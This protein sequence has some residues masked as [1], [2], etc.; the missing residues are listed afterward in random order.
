MKDF[1]IFVRFIRKSSTGM[2]TLAEILTA[3]IAKG[4]KSKAFVAAQLGVSERTVENY[5]KGARS[6]KPEV[7]VKLS[8]ML[9]FELSELSNNE[10]QNVPS[11]NGSTNHIS[12]PTTPYVKNPASNETGLKDELIV[13]YKEQIRLLKQELANSNHL[14]QLITALQLPES[15]HDLTD[16]VKAIAGIVEE[17]R[18]FL[19]RLASLVSDPD[20]SL[21]DQG[22]I[23]TYGST[24]RKAADKS[25]K[26]T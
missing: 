24:R 26:K 16:R 25:G 19:K 1:E 15:L 14:R 17:N 20:E 11:G 21:N 10:V 23:K 9:A 3:K 22:V 4:G 12:E 13:S 5:M 18:V 2:P 7:L 6:P 8:K